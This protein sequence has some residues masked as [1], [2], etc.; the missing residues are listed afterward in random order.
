MAKL[1]FQTPTGMHDILPDEQAYYQR[2]F[3]TAKKFFDFYGYSRID[4]P[5]LEDVE[6]FNRS[7]GE[8]TDIVEKEMYLLKTK[9]GDS[10]ALRPEG[11]ASV[12]RAYF[13]N[14]MVSMPQPVKM[15][16]WGPFF[17]Y[18][19][20]QAGRYRQFHQFGAEVIGD[21]DPF[22]DVQSILILYNILDDLK[23]KNLI[24]RINSIGDDECRGEYKKALSKFLKNKK[25]NLCKDCQERSKTNILRVLDCKDPKCRE[26]IS[27][28]PQTMDYLCEGCRAHLKEVLEYLD[29]LKIPYI[30]DPFL[31]RGLD[32]YT[33]TVFEV[34]VQ[35][36][37][38]GRQEAL[39][40]G[41]RYDIL[42]KAIAGEAVPACG[43]AVGIERVIQKMKDNNVDVSPRKHA[44]VFLA[45]IGPM[46]KKRGMAII[47]EFR[48]A[49]MRI[50]ECFNKDSLKLQL[51]KASKMGIKNVIII[52]QKE[53]IQ[54]TAIIRNMETG[55]Q[56]EVSQ[57]DIVKEIRKTIKED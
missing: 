3:E 19:R 27:Q 44:E 14:G 13:Q 57:E 9:G 23:I 2:I 48:K 24:V 36:P 47:E 1:K 7:V 43:M 12:M 10:L 31:V 55:K 37:E 30:L 38:N 16:Y 5:I 52:G 22:F 28:A 40:G 46:A 33:R 51:A 39:S 42:G 56:S 50:A 32:Y 49:N 34:E 26:V 17:R 4:T 20:P 45:Q 21:E 18:E 54:N 8:G 15:W 6:L 25:N 53:T 29:E 41:G 35:D 11:T